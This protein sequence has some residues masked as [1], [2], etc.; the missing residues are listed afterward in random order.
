MGPRVDRFWLL[1][2]LPEAVVAVARSWERHLVEVD[3]GVVPG[4]PKGT[5]RARSTT[6]TPTP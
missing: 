1:E 6:R 4:A 5:R 2:S 3:T